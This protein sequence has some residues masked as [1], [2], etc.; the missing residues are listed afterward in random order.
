[1]ALALQTLWR[2]KKSQQ[3]KKNRSK[4]QDSQRLGRSIRLINHYCSPTTHPT[5]P[6]LNYRALLVASL[7]LLP[8][9]GLTWA[10]GTLTVNANSTVVAWLFT[11]CNSLQVSYHPVNSIMHGIVIILFTAQGM[12]I[13]FFHVVRNEKVLLLDEYL[14]Y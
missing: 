3:Q 7:I 9:L 12:F 4:F 13:F 14:L 5:P 1:M 8:L 11:I 6:Y 2:V 10:F